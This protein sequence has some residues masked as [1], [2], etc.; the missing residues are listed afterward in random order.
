MN[1]SA[2]GRFS[3]ASDQELRRFAQSVFMGRSLLD[4]LRV[5]IERRA[6]PSMLDVLAHIRAR[7]ASDG[8]ASRIVEMPKRVDTQ[9][10]RSV[11]SARPLAPTKLSES[12][13]GHTVDGKGHHRRAL[14][15][16][17]VP[18]AA[19][20][21]LVAQSNCISIQHVIAAAVMFGLVAAISTG[22]FW[23]AIGCLGATMVYWSE[24]VELFEAMKQQRWPGEIRRINH[25]RRLALE[26]AKQ[27][28]LRCDSLERLR[29]EQLRHREAAESKEEWK[30]EYGEYLASA[31]WKRVRARAM[32]R[33]DGICQDCGGKARH[34]HHLRYTKAH[35]RGDF[36]RQPLKNLVSLCAT[37]HRARHAR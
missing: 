32:K 7:L 23:W 29:L 4:E 11:G 1:P 17:E 2:T 18:A 8:D 37:C 26:V 28:R 20:S 24:L 14:L 6:E 5:E 21:H 22:Q 13:Q 27:E 35:G 10:P 34:V 19:I 12:E 30:R 16:S 3:G 9:Y 15:R 36:S 25:E 31:K 33:D